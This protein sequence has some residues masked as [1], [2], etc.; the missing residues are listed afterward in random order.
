[1]EA[2]ADYKVVPAEKLDSEKYFEV[3]KKMTFSV[4]F[5]SEGRELSD[6]IVTKA[7]KWFLNEPLFGSYFLL[8]NKEDE[9]CGMDF[10]TYE[11]NIYKSQQ[12]AWIQT[13]FVKKEL[14]QGG[15]FRKICEGNE[16]YINKNDKLAKVIK[17]YADVTN[18]KA[19]KA[20][21]KLGFKG[22]EEEFWEFIPDTQSL[23]M[24]KKKEE[25][26][27]V[28]DLSKYEVKTLTLSEF[29]LREE[30]Q[31]F[32][33]LIST[34]KEE[35]DLS[36]YLKAITEVL[37]NE[38]LGRIL[39]LSYDG[40]IVL[41]AFIFYEF[42]DWSNGLMW[43]IYDILVSSNQVESFRSNNDILIYSMIKHSL[44]SQATNLR[45]LINPKEESFLQNTLISKSHYLIMDKNTG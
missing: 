16:E 29:K 5:E 14:R 22:M 12:I 33:S 41:L 31:K 4:A 35:I 17:L 21:L 34:N 30:N 36:L 23:E 15:L 10:L 8:L 9:A 18:E 25:S 32:I 7:I 38:K 37:E 6:E 26:F 43:T 20:Y 11:Y 44:V 24:L 13:A 2:N 27:Q 3:L 1:M 45:I 28:C 39:F 42:S 40:E 19:I